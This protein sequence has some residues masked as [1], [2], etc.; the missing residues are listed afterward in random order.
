[1]AKFLYV[2]P[3][4]TELASQCHIYET[5]DLAPGVYPRDVPLKQQDEWRCVGLMNSKGKLV[6]CIPEHFEELNSCVPLAGG[7]CIRLAREPA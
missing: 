7:L 3:G 5:D 2:Y 4:V 6:H 1:M